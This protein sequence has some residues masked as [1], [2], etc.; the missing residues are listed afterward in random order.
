MT[1]KIYFARVVYGRIK[2]K[3][4]LPIIFYVIPNFDAI[5]ELINI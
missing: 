5:Q 4:L 1:Y 3:I 2:R